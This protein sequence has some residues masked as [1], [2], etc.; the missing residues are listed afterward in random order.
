MGLLV[1]SRHVDEAITIG[2][3]I[4]VIVVAVRGDKVRLGVEA[5]N[6]IPVHRQ[7]V[8]QA[9]RNG[10]RSTASDGG[11]SVYGV[12]LQPLQADGKRL[13]TVVESSSAEAALRLAEDHIST[14]IYLPDRMTVQCFGVA[15]AEARDR[16]GA[17]MFA[18]WVDRHEIV[19]VA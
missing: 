4:R 15:S 17:W 3:D 11:N 16:A 10:N 13:C 14:S 8:Y 12:V 7:E 1:L 2:D 18:K 19:R 6:H 5:P 9:I